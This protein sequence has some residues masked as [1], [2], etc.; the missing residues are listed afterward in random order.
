MANFLQND[1]G[2]RQS[3]ANTAAPT[4]GTYNVFDYVANS[5][6]AAGTPMGWVC[7]AG[8][9]PGTWVAVYPLQNVGNVATLAAAGN[10]A[11]DANILTVTGSGAHNITLALPATANNGTVIN[12]VNT[13]SGTVT[14]VAATGAAIVGLATSATNTSASFKS[15]STTWYRI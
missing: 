6:P 5:S 13:S 3:Q 14:A 11:A 4:S 12:V 10:V 2:V 7:T 8:G 9:S 1:W 15:N